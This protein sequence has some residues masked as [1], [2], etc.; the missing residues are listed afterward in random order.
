MFRKIRLLLILLGLWAPDT[1]GWCY[2]CLRKIYPIFIYFLILYPWTTFITQEAYWSI[3]VFLFINLHLSAI[4]AYISARKYWKRNHLVIFITSTFIPYYDD[5]TKF[6]QNYRKQSDASEYNESE[7]IIDNESETDKDVWDSARKT[8]AQG[9][10]QRYRNDNRRNKRNARLRTGYKTYDD[11]NRKQK[12]K[13][14][15]KKKKSDEDT[16]DIHESLKDIRKS[17]A[18]RDPFKKHNSNLSWASIAGSENKL[19]VSLFYEGTIIIICP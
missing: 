5:L 11:K 3:P 10:Q 2:W 7:S 13:K 16:Y 19:S 15:D 17:M 4:F 8:L 1:K 6:Q 12:T 18:D 14:S 9:F